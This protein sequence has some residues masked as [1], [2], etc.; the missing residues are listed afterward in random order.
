MVSYTRARA[1]SVDVECRVGL[2]ERG[3]RMLVLI[4]GALL[5]LLVPAIWVVALG[6]NATAVH[7]IV[8]TWR[9]TRGVLR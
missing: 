1:E 3:E 5:D 8:H 6:A 9:A 2:M 7:R 4:V